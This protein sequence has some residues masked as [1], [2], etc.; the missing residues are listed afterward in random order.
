ME[1]IKIHPEVA[2]EIANIGKALSHEVRIMILTRLGELG[3]SD[4][5]SL[6]NISF[7][8]LQQHVVVLLRLG[9][10]KKRKSK[11]V[12]EITEEGRHV[13]DALRKLTEVPRIKKKVANIKKQ[14]LKKALVRYGSGLTKEEMIQIVEELNKEIK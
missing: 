9:L 11:G 3:L 10:I 1:D 5:A 2:K 14:Q 8:A 13:V 7:Q 6:M 12:Y 4:I